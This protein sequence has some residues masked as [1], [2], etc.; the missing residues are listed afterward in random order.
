MSGFTG[1]GD[2]LFYHPRRRAGPLNTFNSPIAFGGYHE[3]DSLLMVAA[4]TAAA[5]LLKSK[6]S[7]VGR[8]EAVRRIVETGTEGRPA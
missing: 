2:L 8:Q 6:V 5:R 1:D 4:S 3:Y 7:V